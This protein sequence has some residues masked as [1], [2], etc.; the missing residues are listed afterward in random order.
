[1]VFLE[2]VK[3]PE[4][5]SISGW[6]C[7]C[8]NCPYRA[9]DSSVASATSLKDRHPE[10]VEGSLTILPSSGGPGYATQACVRI[11]IGDYRVLYEVDPTTNI[12]T[13]TA[14]GHRRDLYR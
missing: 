10:P 7:A 11:R 3:M 8:C 12:V 5:R 13:I 4:V 1:L 14:I 2:N 6:P 9:G